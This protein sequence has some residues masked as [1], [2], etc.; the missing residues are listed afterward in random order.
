MQ[1]MYA[2]ISHCYSYWKVVSEEVVSLS[3]HKAIAKDAS[4][5]VIAWVGPGVYRINIIC[6]VA[7]K[8]TSYYFNCFIQYIHNVFG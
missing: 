7:F 2:A 3:T 6:N 1:D 8:F 5:Q 4:I